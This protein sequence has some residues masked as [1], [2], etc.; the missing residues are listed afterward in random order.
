[1]DLPP[2]KILALFM[3]LTIWPYLLRD[4]ALRD[5]VDLATLLDG[6]FRHFQ[7]RLARPTLNRKSKYRPLVVGIT[8]PHV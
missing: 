7:Q 1:M 8:S 3:A 6:V 2:P 5:P 4:L